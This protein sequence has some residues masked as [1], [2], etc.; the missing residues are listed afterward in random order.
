MSTANKNE[1][2]GRMNTVNESDSNYNSTIQALLQT[3]D[4]Q[5]SPDD[6]EA[7]LFLPSFRES[8]D[9]L[10]IDTPDI[11]MELLW[12]IVIYGTQHI[13]ISKS[14]A[15]KASMASIRRTIDTGKKK[16]SKKNKKLST[17]G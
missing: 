14:P 16:Y 11:A 1:N 15:V 2:V 6:Y 7:F 9:N 3:V 8:I 5:E 10:A 17:E 4:T 12:T 13:D